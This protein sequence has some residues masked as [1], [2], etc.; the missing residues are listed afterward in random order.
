[1]S[2]TNLKKDIVLFHGSKGGIKGKIVPIS[3]ENC[4][5]GRGFYLGE[6]KVQASG[7]IANVNDGVLYK[8]NLRLSEMPDEK[9]L[10]VSGMD[11]M[12]MVLAFRGGVPEIMITD[13][14]KEMVDKANRADIVIGPIADDRMSAAISLFE[15]GIITDEV[16][17]NCLRYVDYGNQYVL[18]TEYACSLA[19]VIERHPL[20]GQE[21]TFAF[22]AAEEKRSQSRNII[23]RMVEKYGDRGNRLSALLAERAEKERGDNF[24]H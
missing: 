19:D 4:D 5:F 1:M 16:L 22:S 9:K 12:Y 2:E 14:A 10:F 20:R 15:Q 21:R 17:I 18:K 6:S 7:L 13:R 8:I 23:A 24:E 11:W 3:R